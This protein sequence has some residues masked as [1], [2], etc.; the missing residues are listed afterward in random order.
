MSYDT[1]K[2]DNVNND[3]RICFSVVD[4]LYRMLKKAKI[5]FDD[6]IFSVGEI[7]L[8]YFKKLKHERH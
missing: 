6:L 7:P 8:H 5:V 1:I 4:L 3:L 2:L